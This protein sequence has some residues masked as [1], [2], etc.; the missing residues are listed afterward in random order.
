MM[1]LRGDLYGE[2]IQQLKTHKVLR[3]ALYACCLGG[4][5]D[6]ARWS[7]TRS[8]LFFGGPLA[9]GFEVYFAE[10]SKDSPMRDW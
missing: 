2:G 6:G 4:G 10:R 8:H 3:A 1:L 5:V 7:G 9:P